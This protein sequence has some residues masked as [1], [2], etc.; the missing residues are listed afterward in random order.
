MCLEC[1]HVH[2]IISGAR[3][4]GKGEVVGLGCLVWSLVVSLIWMQDSGSVS[5]YIHFVLCFVLWSEFYDGR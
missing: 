1:V 2:Y 3:G 5:G 4:N